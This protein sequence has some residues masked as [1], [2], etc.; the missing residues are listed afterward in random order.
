MGRISLFSLVLG[1]LALPALAHP[2]PGIK[3]DAPNAI[4]ITP[5]PGLPTLES[6]GLTPEQLYKMTVD[7]LAEDNGT[8]SGPGPGL[9]KRWTDTCHT[10]DYQGYGPDGRMIA[11]DGRM[12]RPAGLQNLAACNIYLQRLDTTR[13]VVG[14]IGGEAT[15]MCTANSFAGEPPAYIAGWG[16]GSIGGYVSSYCRDVAAAVYRVGTACPY[17]CKSGK[18]GKSAVMAA[19]GNGDLIV[20]IAG[21]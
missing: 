1:A 6:L 20:E 19:Q 5:G 3:R 4:H 18:C 14:P 2:S 12:L 17:Y 11:P 7:Y 10:A 13:C 21:Y 9:A 8:P 16:L 15:F